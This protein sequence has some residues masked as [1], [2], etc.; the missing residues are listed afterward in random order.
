MLRLLPGSREETRELGLLRESRAREGWT[1]AEATTS[2]PTGFV[3][4][5]ITPDLPGEEG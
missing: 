2:R 5:P 4:I 1:V 3:E